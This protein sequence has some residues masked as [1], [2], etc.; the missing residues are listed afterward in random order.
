[1]FINADR[2]YKEGKVQNKLRPEDIE[3]IAFTCRHKKVI[4]KYSRLVSKQELADEQYNL[5]IR[6]FVDNAPPA[7]PQDV[8]AHLQGGIPAAE[9]EAL[10]NMFASY[11]GL[12]QQLFTTLK[13]N[14]LQFTPA[15]AQKEDIK[16]LMDESPEVKITLENYTQGLQKWWHTVVHD[17][18]RLPET[19][20]VFELYRRFSESFTSALKAL[21]FG[22]DAT[23][24]VLDTYQ[25]RGALAA[26]WSEL[27]VDLK[28]VA[29]S[30]WNA[31][32]IPDDE[33][34]ESQHPEVLKELRNNEARKEELEAIF[35]EVNELEEDVWKEEDYEV[36]PNKELKEYKEAL[37][38]LTGERKDADKECKNLYKR[39]KAGA[40]NK[41]EL[42]LLAQKLEKEIEALD[43]QIATEE[44]RTE[45]HTSLETEL[46][47]CKKII[48][49]IKDRKQML[50]DQA[51]I[52]ITPDEARQLILK[53]W[54]SVLHQTI[55][56]YLQAHSRALL[57]AIENLNGKY[58]TPLQSILNEREKETEL[59]NSFLIEL[60]YE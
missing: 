1:L 12:R 34:L 60:G 32:L 51:R 39:I 3:K 8:H 30:G 45:K 22:K 55:D 11:P 48:K 18:E 17:F 13:Q 59:L 31:E 53:R 20:N 10:Q 58:T 23:G 6:R 29:A 42:K 43:K 35:N 46:K 25:S 49:Q 41:A 36:W 33:I 40:D 44:A 5:N 2:E 56:S 14:Y 21:P 4:D 19:K 38:A 15:I 9:V 27:N 26:Y 50:V 28:S 37:K 16:K 47:Q 54:N 24:A 52:V 57:Q 7:E